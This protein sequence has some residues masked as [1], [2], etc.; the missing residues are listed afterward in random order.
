[1][2]T[3]DVKLLGTW[4]CPYVNRVQLA[5]KLKS[6]EYEFIEDNPYN[7]SEILVKN[8]PVLKK[9]PVLI[10]GNKPVCESL[11]IV[12]Y[13]DDAWPIGPSLLPSDA[14]DRALARFWAAY[15]DDKWYPLIKMLRQAEGKE[16]KEAIIAKLAEGLILLED[17]FVICGKGKDY[18]GGENIGYIDIVLGSSLAWL[19]VTEIVVGVQL[20]DQTRTPGLAK[21]AE[22][23]ISNDVFKDVLPETKKLLELHE[24]IQ[25]FI[26][27]S[28]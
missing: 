25:A 20:L 5:L 13:I 6:I 4:S 21:W 12:Q 22:R 1:M 16:E 17:A 24:K 23:V 11:I 7:R 18:F 26:K 15:T 8:N 27:S 3:R 19:R 10:H 9:I 2:A 28:T 14:Y